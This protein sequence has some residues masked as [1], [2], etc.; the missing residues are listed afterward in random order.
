MELREISSH[1]LAAFCRLQQIEL[2]LT[3]KNWAKSLRKCSIFFSLES[4]SSDVRLLIAIKAQQN[5][6]KKTAN[7]MC[8]QDLFFIVIIIPFKRACSCSRRMC[9][10]MPVHYAYYSDDLLLDYTIQT[11]KDYPHWVRRE[12]LHTV[13]IVQNTLK[14]QFFQFYIPFIFITWVSLAHSQLKICIHCYLLIRKFDA[15]L[16]LPHVSTVYYLL[17]VSNI[18]TCVWNTF[19]LWFAPDILIHFKSC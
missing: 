18:S 4:N 3:V 5:R 8:L 17:C 2:G 6:S 14:C 7:K 12:Q 15:A 9:M 10:P 1:R 16:V 19:Y 13:T 11:A